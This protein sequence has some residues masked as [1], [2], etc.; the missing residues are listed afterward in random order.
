MLGCVLGIL[1]F[2]FGQQAP[3]RAKVDPTSE[4]QRFQ[5][6]MK[7]FD[8]E[9]ARLQVK[10]KQAFDSELAAETAGDCPDI[11]MTYELN[12]CY[13][14]VLTAARQNLAAYVRAIRDILNLEEPRFNGELANP[15]PDGMPLT[16][17]KELAELDLVERT[18]RPYVDAACAAH[19]H[20]YGGGSGGP[21][22]ELACR[23][24]LTRSHMK[25]LGTVYGMLLLK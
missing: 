1:R 21:G 15:G 13:S 14:K 3:Q 6:R 12:E 8:A 4:D 9:V 18:W 16:R 2:G 23:I 17:E 24:R 5:Q 19:H 10:A 7:Q 20:Q 11:V 22:A 25:D